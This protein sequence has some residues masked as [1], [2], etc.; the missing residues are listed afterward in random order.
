MKETVSSEA[1]QLLIL[2]G[3]LLVTILLSC[4]RGLC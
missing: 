3:A 4:I 2:L 1:I